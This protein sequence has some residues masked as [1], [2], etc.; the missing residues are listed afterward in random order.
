MMDDTMMVLIDTSRATEFEEWIDNHA[1]ALIDDRNTFLKYEFWDEAGV[2]AF[3]AK[4]DDKLQDLTDSPPNYRGLVVEF[5]SVVLGLEM[6]IHRWIKRNTTGAR[7]TMSTAF[8][9]EVMQ[10]PGSFVS[11]CERLF[12]AQ[13][14]A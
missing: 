10:S 4:W 7:L 14:A 5:G 8:V 1:N 6:M 2:E 11:Q 3:R 12:Q 13:V 9:C